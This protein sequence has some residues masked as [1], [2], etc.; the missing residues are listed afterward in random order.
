MSEHRS[1]AGTIYVLEQ[2]QEETLAFSHHDLS[3]EAAVPTT[4]GPGVERYTGTPL[5][6][7]GY[8]TGPVIEICWLPSEGR[9]GLAC[10][11]DADW[12]DAESAADALERY[13]GI[14]NKSMAN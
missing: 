5:T 3:E 9:A 6:S 2:D 13:L 11:A 14:D 4:D 8:R 12:T 7:D 10:G 1:P